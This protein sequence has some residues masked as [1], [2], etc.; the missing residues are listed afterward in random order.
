MTA[1]NLEFKKIENEE[2]FE[3]YSNIL[4][5]LMNIEEKTTKE[6]NNLNVVSILLQDYENRVHKPKLDTMM[7][8]MTPIEWIE[9]AMDNLGLIQNDLIPFIGNKGRVSEVMNGKRKLSSNMIINLSKALNI[10]LEMLS[11]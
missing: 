11:K 2:E 5:D 7:S 6:I 10:P 8:E 9:G 1:T 4:T 3:F